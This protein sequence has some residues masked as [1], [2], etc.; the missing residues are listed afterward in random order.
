[1][2]RT[3]TEEFIAVAVDADALQ[4]QQ[5]AEGQFARASGMYLGGSACGTS[6]ITAAGKVLHK[7]SGGPHMGVIEKVLQAWNKLPASERAPG[8]IK[9][10]EK[11]PKDEKHVAAEPPPGGLILKLHGRYLARATTGELRITTLL[12]DFPEKNLQAAAKAHPGHLDYYCEANPDFMWLTESEW[13]SLVPVDARKGDQCPLPAFFM[14]RMCR[15]HLLPTT[16]HSRIG[17]LWEY[18]GPKENRG[19]RA[20]KV[21]LTVEDVSPTNIRLTLEGFVHLGHAFDPVATARVPPKKL[22]CLGYEANIRGV[23]DYD[24]KKRAFTRLD[25]VVLGDLYGDTDG[26]DWLGRPGRNP[27]A[28]AF[29]LC[30]GVEPTHRLPPRGY[31]TRKDL[32]VYLGRGK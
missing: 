4:E 5:D 28:F 9:I 19:I 32:E 20:K 7:D 27:M 25:I 11:G 13:K 16:M 30:S 17:Y 10:G 12:K 2:V 6:Y 14:E 15:Y 22:Q 31:S 3:L 1:V 21:T 18:I 26:N 29:E 23:L 8:A 24:P